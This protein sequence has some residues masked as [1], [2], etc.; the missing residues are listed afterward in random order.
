MVSRRSPEGSWLEVS[1]DYC[2]VVAM[3]NPG[4]RV[5]ECRDGLAWSLQ[6]RRPPEQHSPK[7]AYGYESRRSPQRPCGRIPKGVALPDDAWRGRFYCETS[8]QLRRYVL[9]YAGKIDDPMA[10]AV[11]AW[12]PERI[13]APRK[14]QAEVVLDRLYEDLKRAPIVGAA[15]KTRCKQPVDAPV[16]E[17]AI[18]APPDDFQRIGTSASHGGMASTLS[19]MIRIKAQAYRSESRHQGMGGAI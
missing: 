3:L 13:G 1:S 10:W 6:R 15:P 5:I 18:P 2:A 12:L 7:S 11:L 9:A 8:E 14:T 16:R 17:P 4:W 19:A